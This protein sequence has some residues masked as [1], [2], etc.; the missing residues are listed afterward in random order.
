[1]TLI[2]K[3]SSPEQSGCYS[4]TVYSTSQLH[5]SCHVYNTHLGALLSYVPAASIHPR[6]RAVSTMASEACCTCATIIC[7]YPT[8][9]ETKN[10]KQASTP[11][12]RRLDCCSRV[13]CATC[14]HVCHML[15][16]PSPSA[17]ETRLL[18]DCWE[19]GYAR[20]ADKAPD[21]KTPASPP[22]APTAR[23]QPIPPTL[24]R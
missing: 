8:S 23:S 1:M 4:I 17:Q 10:E 14:I 12:D 22:T 18:W 15:S 6:P 19:T 16:L 2:D 13:I 24:C 11:D 9:F 20:R 3:Q 21:R 5:V 7:D